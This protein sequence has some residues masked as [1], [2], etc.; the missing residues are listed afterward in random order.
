MN[1]TIDKVYSADKFKEVATQ[2]I[3]V[4]KTY[5]LDS[6]NRE[7]KVQNWKAPKDQL[8]FWRNYQFDK[9]NP[10]QFFKDVIYGS[11]NVQHPQ[12]MGHQ[13]SPPAPVAALASLLGSILNNGM[14]VYE[15][16]A[17]ATVIERL[18]IEDLN[19]RLGFKT[20][21]ADGFITSGG[22]LANL[23]ALLTA[24]QA[25][26]KEDVWENG[27][28]QKLG[29]MVS[30]EAHYCVDRAARI[31]GF[32][33]DGVI[34]IPVDEQ[35]RIRTDKLDEHYKEATQKGIKVIA[36]VGSAPSTSTGMHDDLISLGKFAKENNLWFHVDG[37]H[38]G[39]AIFS[40]KYQHYLK[41]IEQADSVVIDGHKMLMIP[42]IMTFLLYKNKK[43]ANATFTQKAQ[44]LLDTTE[45]DK[46]YDIALK[47]FECTKRM[48]G[49]QFY[50]LHQMYGEALFDEFVTTLY[51][52]GNSFS[53]L[54]QNHP[55]F[56]LAVEPDTNIV[57]FRYFR[58]DISKEKTDEINRK[59]RQQLLEEGAFYI[60]Q[61]KL[62][63]QV[64]LRTTIMNPMTQIKDFENLLERL[65]LLASEMN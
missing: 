47:S 3:D 46:W 24:R 60:V 21:K 29:I 6:Q 39:A 27:L 16:G 8:D 37:A 25:M 64:Y 57:C 23:T 50:I 40:K 33:N 34:K 18:V 2:L 28:Q 14:A 10:H 61:T 19:K 44:Y 26:V 32:G 38:G 5:L 35:F 63:N 12:Y 11:V 58:K 30:S 51:D 42:A 55:N 54:I 56:Q 15:M 1:N 48:M 31:M 43:Y 4:I 17:A 59:I 9:E 52:L 7:L 20:E 13:I 36:I 53:K 65:T 22:T 62:R 49:I 41:G 45:E